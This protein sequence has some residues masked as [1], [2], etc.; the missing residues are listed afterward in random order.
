MQSITAIT[1]SDARARLFPLIQEI[2]ED[3]TTV[4][5]TSKH[6]TV[7]LMSEAEYRGIMETLFVMGDPLNAKRISEAM[8]D[9][10]NGVPFIPVDP[11]TLKRL[12]E[13]RL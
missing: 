3:E 9:L 4:H 5:I 12:D 8:L 6:G 7:V 1:A 13:P 11:K 2:V 10:L